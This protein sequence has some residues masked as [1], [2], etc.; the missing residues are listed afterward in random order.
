MIIDEPTNMGGKDTGANP[1]GTLLGALAGCEN[2]VTNMV[3]KEIDFNLKG[4]EFTFKANLTHE[5][6]WEIRMFIPILKKYQ[7]MQK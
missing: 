7:L 5:D 3:A 6:S 4:I 1:L 2:V